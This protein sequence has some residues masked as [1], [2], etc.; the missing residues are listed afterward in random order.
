MA[1]G[2]NLPRQQPGEP[3]PAFHH[4]QNASA[5]EGLARLRVGRGLVQTV[6]N[7]IPV[8]SLASVAAVATGFTVAM[9]E[10]GG[11]PARHGNV[12][13]SATCSLWSIIQSGSQ[14][15]LDASDE[16]QTVL[17]LASEAV[18]GHAVIV[19]AQIDAQWVCLY[20]LCDNTDAPDGSQGSGA[21]PNSVPSVDKWQGRTVQSP[22]TTRQRQG[23]TTVKPLN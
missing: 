15:L 8:I 10:A 16:N 6:V 11:I 17:N 4:N 2:K 5:I 18:S 14:Y 20:E 7:G 9:T 12:L 21:I 13:G 1:W 3:I 22:K 19:A 23:T